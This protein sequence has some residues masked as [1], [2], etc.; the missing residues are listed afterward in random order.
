MT[1][2]RAKLD[3]FDLY[4]TADGIDD[5][6][7]KNVVEYDI[8]FSDGAI[9]DQLGIKSRKIN[10]RSVW[11]NDTYSSH[12]AF[13]KHCLKDATNTLIHPK[14][15]T[16]K[17]RVSLVS[18][19]NDGNSPKL[20]YVDVTFIEDTNPDVEPVYSPGLSAV[21]DDCIIASQLSEM[22]R[23]AA[24]VNAVLGPAG[25]RVLAVA[26]DPDHG[27]LG[28]LQRLS[29]VGRLWISKVET[30][31]NAIDA[32]FAN[33]TNPVESL[34]STIN[35]G[36]SLAGRVMGS[37]ARS[38]ERC[39]LAVKQTVDSPLAFIYAFRGAS[40]SL[41]STAGILG[42][43][44]IS[45][46][47][48]FAATYMAQLYTADQKKRDEQLKTENQ[49]AWGYDGKLKFTP[50]LPAVLTIND[51]EMSIKIYR[52]TAQYAIDSIRADLGSAE[53]TRQIH[54]ICNNLT[55][56]VDSTKLNRERI[57]AIEVLDPIPVHLLC[58]Q[59]G[60]PYTAAERVCAINN[61][62]CP[63]FV[64]GKVKMYVR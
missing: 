44:I 32:A 62:D 28:Q 42:K 14:Y 52:E 17:G 20:A 6:W 13:V 16:I 24:D 23:F 33:I 15:G 55:E 56:Y 35:Y 38:V 63:N 31:V 9:L 61:F 41:L 59:Y 53:L 10:F 5:V 11:W 48:Q 54:T 21:V 7:S 60:L 12:E 57:I 29:I 51:I 26:L 22:E 34:L 8:P 49:Q 2:Y 30:A 3:F 43:Y 37:V 40:D 46:L 18:V 27:I 50:S 58:L 39:A 36:N 45:G 1:Q 19:K 47:P 25:P 64:S 4:I